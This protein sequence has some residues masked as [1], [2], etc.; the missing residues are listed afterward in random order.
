VTHIFPRDFLWGA[1]TA[2]HQIEGNNLNSDWWKLEHDVPDYVQFSGDAIDS[3]H[4][5][6]EDM[7]LLAD[8]GFNAYRFSVEWSR[9]ERRNQS[10]M[11]THDLPADR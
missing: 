4:R 1:S 6:E 3:Y 11:A 9:I 8:A 7:R 2:A 10:V 5:F